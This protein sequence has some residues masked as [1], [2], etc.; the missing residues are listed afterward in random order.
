MGVIE[1]LFKGKSI[2]SLSGK[3]K[4]RLP[5]GITPRQKEEAEKAA[6]DTPVNLKKEWE[7]NWD[8]ISIPGDV[9]DWTFDGPS[10]IY[11]TPRVPGE[12]RHH[13]ET[14]KYTRNKP[15]TTRG[16]FQ[17]TDTGYVRMDLLMEA[18]KINGRLHN[19]TVRV[20]ADLTIMEATVKTRVVSMES[21]ITNQA[22]SLMKMADLVEELRRQ[23]GVSEEE[24][25]AIMLELEN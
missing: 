25:T 24:T 10:V 22:A 2:S 18:R 4:Q 6:K 7:A 14:A 8:D 16:G 20:H 15:H 3:M 23:L 1:D 19:T 5:I 12:D 9:E 17:R 13:S 11:L 21:T